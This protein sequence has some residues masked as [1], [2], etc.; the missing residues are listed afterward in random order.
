MLTDEAP[1]HGWGWEGLDEEAV[2]RKRD[3]SPMTAVVSKIEAR[4]PIV[5]AQLGSA[6]P[7]IKF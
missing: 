1:R 6:P 3:V 2:R 4:D 5:A 7:E